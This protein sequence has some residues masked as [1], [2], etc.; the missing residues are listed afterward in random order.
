MSNLLRHLFEDETMSR[1]DIE[2]ASVFNC[3]WNSAHI[4]RKRKLLFVRLKR[5]ECPIS[6]TEI[7]K[8]LRENWA[9]LDVAPNFISALKAYIVLPISTCEAERSIF[10][11]RKLKTYLPSTIT[12][13]RLNDLT[14]LTTHR[15]K[16]EALDLNEVVTEFAS[17]SQIRRNKFGVQVQ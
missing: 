15:D 1:D 9:I 14:A 11:L 17:R 3:D 2:G 13:Q 4:T 7:C 10:T 6:I 16:T 8:Q 12:Q 5:M